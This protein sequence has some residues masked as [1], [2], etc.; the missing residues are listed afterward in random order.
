MSRSITSSAR[1]LIFRVITPRGPHTRGPRDSR[2][3]PYLTRRGPGLGTHRAGCFMRRQRQRWGPSQAVSTHTACQSHCS[4]P[5]SHVYCISLAL[6]FADKCVQSCCAA[7][8][9]LCGRYTKAHLLQICFTNE[10]P[11]RFHHATV[12]F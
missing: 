11:P 4:V 6:I 7:P 5:S 1:T 3:L 10:L 9:S 2:C 8:L 12:P